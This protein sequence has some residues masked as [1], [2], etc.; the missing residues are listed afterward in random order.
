M[1]FQAISKMSEDEARA[2]FE[3]IRWPNGPICPHCGSVESV[4]LGWKADD[5]D[6]PRKS[7]KHRPGL[8]KCGGCRADF[9]ATINTILEDSH[10]PIRTWL[11]AFAMMCAS[12]KGVS[13]LQLQ[14]QLGIGSY[15]SAWHMCHRIRHAMGKEPMK[16]LLGSTGGTVEVDEM[17][18]GAKRVRKH[19]QRKRRPI[20]VALVERGGRARAF[21]IKRVDAKTLKAAIRANVDREAGIHTDEHGAYQ[22]IGDE[23]RGGHHTVNH[24]ADE[25]AR[26]SVTSN[27]VE[28]YFALLRRGLTGSFHHVSEQ[29]LAKYC[30]EFSFRWSARQMSDGARTVE[31]IKSSEGRRLT[32]RSPIG[33]T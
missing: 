22:G 26:D 17:R 30:D 9:T 19:T 2:A 21:P 28:S 3:R 11:L 1:D 6:K 15:R 7:A 33:K 13:A 27:S 31:A 29:H 4:E 16:G 8:R 5:A 14:R 10:L 32:Y 25:F 18:A 12:K 24:S 23:Y 20:I